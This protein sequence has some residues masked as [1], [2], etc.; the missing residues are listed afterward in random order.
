MPKIGQKCEKMNKATII[1]KNISLER[2]YSYM[3]VTIFEKIISQDQEY[4]EH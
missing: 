3:C 1:S 4:C 2:I